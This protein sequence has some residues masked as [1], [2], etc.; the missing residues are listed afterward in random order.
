MYVENGSKNNSGVSL[1]INN[2]VVPVY[3]NT[4][5]GQRCL[6]AL[7]DKYISKLPPAVFE[8]DIFYMRPKPATPCDATSP[9]YEGIP[10]GK[11]SLRTMLPNMCE[12]AEIECKTNHSLRATGATEMFAA[13]VPEKL[14]Q[15]RTGHRSTEAFR[16]YERPSHDQHQAVSNILTSSEHQKSFSKELS[17]IQSAAPEETDQQQAKSRSFGTEVTNIKSFASQSN[18]STSLMS[19]IQN[20]SDL[21][22]NLNHC[23]VN[24]NFNMSSQKRVEE[25]FDYLVKNMPF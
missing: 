3:A 24:I 7:L 17:T 22:G 23:S 18:T 25:E 5:N 14:I 15:S 11:E 13:N 16:F 19:S 12:R 6:V 21:F 4:L 20:H 1:K 8:K 9:W 2:K 10:V